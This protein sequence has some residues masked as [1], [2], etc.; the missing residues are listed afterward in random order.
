MGLNEPV[1]KGRSNCLVDLDLL[2]HVSWICVPLVFVMKHA[3]VNFIAKLRHMVH[4]VKSLF[5]DFANMTVYLVFA[6][7]A[8]HLKLLVKADSRKLVPRRGPVSV[9]DFLLPTDLVT[10]PAD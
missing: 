4:I 3:L 1:N 10:D 6:P 5:I 9:I 7:L 2:A 8:E